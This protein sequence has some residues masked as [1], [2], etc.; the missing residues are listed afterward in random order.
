MAGEYQTPPP[1]LNDPFEHP[2]LGQPWVSANV[3]DV[4]RRLNIALVD[5]QEACWWIAFGTYGD[6]GIGPI[7]AYFVA[8]P[9]DTVRITEG[10]RIRFNLARD[11]LFRLIVEGRAGL[12][13]LLSEKE[14]VKVFGE[15]KY[16]RNLHRLYQSSLP[17]DELSKFIDSAFWVERELLESGDWDPGY[18]LRGVV[19]ESLFVDYL[20]LQ[21]CFDAGDLLNA[22]ASGQDEDDQ[23]QIPASDLKRRGRR[24]VWD[25]DLIMRELVLLAHTQGLPEKQAELEEWVA[26]LCLNPGFPRWVGFRLTFW[27]C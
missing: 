24:R 26:D 5:F 12:L 17:A 10:Q 7:R 27:R 25:W 21:E 16:F 22:S 3:D 6:P 1:D 15:R 4:E 13:G 20:K 14:S 8:D 23:A 11:Q 2:I 18:Q 19:F 9:R